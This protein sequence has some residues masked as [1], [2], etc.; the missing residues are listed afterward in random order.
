MAKRLILLVT[1]IAMAVTMFLPVSAETPDSL[2]DSVVTSVDYRTESPAD[3]TGN[4]NFTK[5]PEDV[6]YVEY[7]G[8][9]C[10]DRT[11]LTAE[12]TNE[13]FRMQYQDGNYQTLNEVFTVEAYVYMTEDVYLSLIH[14]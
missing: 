12:G 9:T 8:V 6:T 3:L 11:S 13:G 4:L 2:K 1:A 7:E 14:I 10:V 5:T